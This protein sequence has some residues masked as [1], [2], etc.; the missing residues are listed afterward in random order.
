MKI[1]SNYAYGLNSNLNKCRK[2]CFKASL[3]PSL[4]EDLIKQAKEDGLLFE[5]TQKEK[6][7]SDWGSPKSFI[8]SETKDRGLDNSVEVLQLDNY[9]IADTVGGNLDVDSDAKLI[10][11]FLSLSENKV[12]DAE[13]DLQRQV[14]ARVANVVRKAMT[15]KDFMIELC[16]EH[17]S[18]IKKIEKAVRNLPEQKILEIALD[19]KPTND[20]KDIINLINNIIGVA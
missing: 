13:K 5:F 1:S 15:N 12:L 16:G 18:D 3:T 6:K 9:Q 8:T 14:N 20:E 7:L 11:Q 17:T 19:Y 2:P 10:D 4:R